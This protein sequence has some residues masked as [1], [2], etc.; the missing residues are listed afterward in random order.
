MS[1]RVVIFTLLLAVGAAA[2]GG[3][4]LG[5]WLVAHAPIAA[6]PPNPVGNDPDAVV[7][8]ADGKPYLAQPPQPLVNGVLGVPDAPMP[9]RWNA[10]KASLLIVNT[11]PDV[12]VSANKLSE[13]ELRHI[14]QADARLPDGPADVLAVD[15]PTPGQ[16]SLV[17][18]QQV[19]ANTTPVVSAHAGHWQASLRNELTQCARLGFFDRPSCAWGA[20]NRY[21]APNQAW[22]TIPECP[23]RP[24]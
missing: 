22:G 17:T 11:N 9:V 13:A 16:G 14:A 10:P 24:D 1:W 23:K 12:W 20:R 18:P 19:A 21:C 5:D 6:A 3:V 4:Q 2:F 7:L 8:D 15:L